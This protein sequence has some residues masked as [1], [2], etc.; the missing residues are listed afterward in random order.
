MACAST[1]HSRRQHFRAGHTYLDGSAVEQAQRVLER[2]DAFLGETDS[3]G[4][5]VSLDRVAIVAVVGNDDGAHHVGAELFQGLND[6]GFSIP[7]SGMT[8]WVG[9]AMHKTDYKDLPSGSGKT[10]QATKT[11]AANAARLARILADRPYPIRGVRAMSVVIDPP[12]DF[13]P[14]HGRPLPLHGPPCPTPRGTLSGAVLSALRQS[15]GSLGPMPP[16]AVDA[17]SDDDLH[18]ALYCCYELHYRGLAGVDP[19]WEWDPA[20][21]GFRAGLEGALLQRLRDEIG[22]SVCLA[23]VGSALDELIAAASGPSLSTFLLESGSLGQL[24]EFCVHRSAYQLKE[25]DPH[26]FAIPRLWGEAKAAMVEIQY[27]EYGSGRA[28]SMHST[29]FADTMTTLGLDSTYGAYLD[30]LPGPTLATVN[31]ASMFGLHR[32][33]RAAMVGHLAVFEMT[34][35]VPMERYSRA[36]ARLGI[37]PKGRRFYDVHVAADARHG[38]IAR[39]RMVAG[40]IET[41]PDLGQDL[42]FGA[43]AVLL[44]EKRFARHLLDAWS[45]G[46]SSLLLAGMDLSE[47]VPH[48]DQNQPNE[49]PSCSTSGL[50]PRDS[51]L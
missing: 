26:T 50:G 47:C 13:L 38:A 36:L 16:V 15:P 12:I 29:L 25:A 31:L 5:M 14:S 45:T 11:T 19:A 7:A 37:G 10:D 2:L 28:A 42:L 22:P 34:S 24:K 20:L 6:I 40:L 43:A 48:H 18:L 51:G 35:I 1:A 30:K 44:V 3:G 23:D 49:S 21:L 27:D 39:D 32:R 9:E 33:W 41:E 46:S 8:Y 4:R 17:L